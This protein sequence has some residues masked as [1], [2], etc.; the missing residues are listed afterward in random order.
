MKQIF[1]IAIFVFVFP[2]SVLAETSVEGLLDKVD[3]LYRSDS[4]HATMEMKI[5]TEN[6][7]RTTVMEVWSRGMNDT[8]IKI[9][10]PRKDKGIKT[11]K[12]GNQMWNYFPKINKVLKV[13][14]SM[15]MNSW[16][17]S[18]FTNDDLVKENTLAEDYHA[19]LEE[20]PSGPNQFYFIVLRPKN[21]TVTVWGK[22]SISIR[23]QDFM[24]VEQIYYNEDG[25]KKRVMEFSGIQQMGG[26]M[27]PAVMEM[28]TLNKNSRTL[29][30]YKSIDFK[31]VFSKSIFSFSQLRRK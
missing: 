27:I 5:V 29:I 12:L 13:P 6:W 8:L 28:R 17:G 25:E 10:S 9:L 7:E 31:P 30:R 23:R 3:R 22:I 21:E 24:P 14:P 2:F 11:L 26:K 16:M 1:G 15:M 19:K 18:D 4:S 20:H